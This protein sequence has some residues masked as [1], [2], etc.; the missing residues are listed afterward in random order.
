MKA[1]E[2]VEA[3]VNVIRLK[4]LA[5][6]TEDCYSGWL[7]RFIRFLTVRRPEGTTEEK[8][9]AFLTQLA[10]QGM[11]ASTQNQAFN[12][13]LFF[14]REVRKVEVGNIDALRAK[15]PEMIRTAPEVSEVAQLLRVVQDVGGYPTRLIVQMLYGMGLRVSEPLNLRIKDLR[16]E[17]SSLMICGAKGGKDRMVSLPCSLIPAIREQMLHAR[18]VA[19]Q[20]RMRRLPI[21]L[22]GLLA[23]KFPQ[24]QFAPKWAWLFP[25]NSPCEDER[26][27]QTVRWRCHEA[28]VQRAVRTAARTLGL[29]V[30]PHN[31]RH[32]Y[33]THSLGRGVN[34]KALQ[35]AMGHTNSDTTLRYCHASALSVP[36]P[37][38]HLP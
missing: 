24:W 18:A 35:L 30:T 33:A 37:L 31:L 36:S 11:A 17:E 9:E 3:L 34:V 6:S 32:A 16:L 10:R 23:V 12:A 28:N 21:A 1:E 19:E 29:C 5:R 14:Y 38:E 20:D 7:R 25:A 26:T 13:V 27:G 22:P 15:R 8:I 2:A 4:H